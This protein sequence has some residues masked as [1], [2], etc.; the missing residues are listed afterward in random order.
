MYLIYTYSNENKR[1]QRLLSIENKKKKKKKIRTTQGNLV[2]IE[3]APIR[4]PPCRYSFPITR[5]R[6]T[7]DPNSSRR[8]NRS[9]MGEHIPVTTSI[10]TSVEERT[11]PKVV[12]IMGATGSGKSRLAIDISSFFPVEIINA[13]SMQVFLSVF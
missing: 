8:G 5:I 10:P 6:S 3:P 11:K 2:L 1:V 7:F 13:D 9:E 12:V 4:C